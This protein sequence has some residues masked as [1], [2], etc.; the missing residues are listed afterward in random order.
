[1]G[2]FYSLLTAVGKYDYNGIKDL[3]SYEMDLKL[4]K[5]ALTEG[6]KF[7]EDAI[8]CPGRD[9]YIGIRTFARALNEFSSLIKEDDGFVYYFSGHGSNGNLCFSDD[10]IALQSIVDFMEKLKARKKILILDCCYSGRFHVSEIKQMDFE[11]TISSFAGAGTAVLASSASDERSWLGPGKNHSLYTGMLTTAM[12][13]NR[14]VRKGRVSLAD[15]HEEV[16]NIARFWNAGNPHKI[17]HPIYRAS[18]CGTI[19]FDVEEYNPY[20][21]L[22]VYLE[23]ENYTIKNVEP[24][25]SLEEKRLAVFVLIH[26]K[27]DKKEL[28]IITRRIA[29]FV[30]DVNVFSTKK[31]EERF[32]NK[33]TKAIW[34]YFGYDESDMVNHRYFSRSIWCSDRNTKKKY[35]R[36]DKNSEVI[37]GVWVSQDLLYESVRKLQQSDISR[38]EF[39]YRMQGLL[40]KIVSMAEKYISDIREID[41]Q[42]KTIS[43]VRS[44]YVHWIREVYEEYYKMTEMPVAPDDLI[45]RFKIIED[46]AGC[47]L[48]MAMLLNKETEYS[49]SNRW[50]IQN[51]I[52]RYYEGLEKLK[53]LDEKT[54]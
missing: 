5:T 14:R 40:T 54:E 6:L 50:M 42:T 3:P 2:K 53:Y 1:M 36:K 10:R 45:D 11:E 49:G 38:E 13:L 34:C 22:Q 43:V 8:R 24:L 30:K 27:C 20:E 29:E 21:T 15:I 32:R 52:R 44:S 35:F 51:S 9:G 39:E 18:I 4:M 46:L 37:K 23:K 25:S 26:N 33:K 41:N 17:Q 19:Y 7:S 47:V 16:I 48:D 28:A 31:S 12:T